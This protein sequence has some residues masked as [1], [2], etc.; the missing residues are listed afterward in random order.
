MKANNDDQ[1]RN[2]FP[3]SISFYGWFA[4]KYLS[5]SFY[6]IISECY[7]GKLLNIKYGMIGK[8]IFFNIYFL[9]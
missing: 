5:L 1:E 3:H 2:L 4:R 6:V 8:C 7:R 9:W